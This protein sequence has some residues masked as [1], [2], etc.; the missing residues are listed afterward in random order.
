MKKLFEK[1]I[2][3][4]WGIMVAVI[5]LSVFFF[6]KMKENT[7]METNL[8]KYMPQDHP[9]FVY[10]NKAEKWFDIKDGII[11]A[12]QNKNGI[13]NPKTLQIIKDLS[14]KFMKMKEINK[15]DVTSLYTADNIVGTED[16]MDV[17]R[18]YRRVPKSKEKLKELEKNVRNNP[19]IYGMIVD[20][21]QTVAVVIA[22]IGDDVFS[23][24]FYERIL[25][26]AKKYEDKD[27]K[28][29]VAGR[30]IVEG[31]L[32]LLG[33]ADMK[34]MV[35]IVLIV[36]FIV[37]YLTLRS[38]KST[39]ATLLVVFFSTLWAFGL[40]AAVN[41]PIYSV[42]TMIPVMLIAIGVAYGIHLYHHLSLFIAENPDAPKEEA[43]IDML[44]QMWKPVSMAAVTTAV[45]FISLLTSQ[46]YPIK[47]FGL[48]TAF[49][50]TMAMFLS[51][52]FIP[53]FIQITGLP[54]VK[55]KINFD[56][57]GE[58]DELAFKFTD[59]VL[60]HSTFTIII[61]A[62]IIVLSIYGMTKVWINS[63]FLDKFEK[64]SDIV[65]TDAFINEHFGGTSTIN[66]ILDG[67][68]KNTFK[69][70][71]VLKLVNKMQHDV[72]NHVPVVGSAF[73]LVDFLNRINQVMHADSAKY[74]R[75]PDSQD[76][77]AQYLLLYE[78]SGD[79]EN[80]TKV[81]DYKYKK[82]NLTFQLKSDNSKATKSALAAIEK[83]KDDFKKLGVKM[84]YAGSGYKALVFTD[85]I[86]EGQIMSLV[87]SIFIVFIL[88]LIM[89]RNFKVSIIGTVPILVTA[90]ISFGIM[91]WLDIPLNS[92]TALLS[93]IAVGIGID[94][95]IHFI[96]R[97]R[98]NVKIGD[99]LLASKVTMSESGKA[100]LFN[101]IVVIAGF[102]VLLFS[103]FPPNR[104]LG[105]LVSINMFTSFLGTLTIM[106]LLL[107]KS[108]V[109]YEKIKGEKNEKV[110]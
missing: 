73:S 27:N 11:V 54:K 38:L 59:I 67:K 68:E 96:E 45:G 79:P 92:T 31:T 10:S 7:R 16:G 82:L 19:M 105:F 17:R 42:S 48:F 78:M 87:M 30:P 108:N 75:I 33:P 85:L 97:Y 102:L 99:K 84:N 81:V 89:F 53:A 61:T 25:K 9:A 12:V 74:Y 64:D 43:I 47:Y 36:I 4:S 14:K 70:P 101:A 46:V 1:S 80:L 50:V 65:K 23:Q 110:N 95:A 8:D 100:I 49:G 41:I 28:I 57:N 60:K 2:K 83:Y 15:N 52:F 5:L 62:V 104:E 29:Y 88:L 94:Y 93:S 98:I 37:L 86:L 39:I 13:Y 76:L 56:A 35:P 18:F 58:K 21:S 69:R 26:I 55:R 40:M 72:V 24:E 3:Y 71:D 63:S 6:F 106:F 34:R 44:M 90:F 66:L 91:G 77:I 51:L 22:R 20:S 107:Y 103:V 32:A 109:Y